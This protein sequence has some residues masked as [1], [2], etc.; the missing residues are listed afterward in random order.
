MGVWRRWVRRT[1]GAL[2][3]SG[4]ESGGQAKM[5]GE[6][7]ATAGVAPVFL[8]LLFPVVATGMQLPP[9]IQADRYLLRAERQI[10]EQNFAGAKVAMDEILELQAQH[11]LELPDDFLFRYADVLARLDLHDEAIEYVTQYLTLAGRGR[12]VLSRSIGTLECRSRDVT[13]S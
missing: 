6:L 13:A 7:R 1:A 10:Q 11:D 9:D 8:W 5:V 2:L 12:R 3:T 4:L